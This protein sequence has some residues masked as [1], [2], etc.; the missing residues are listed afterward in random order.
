MP[1]CV[2]EN[3]F[4][5]F[6]KFGIKAFCC[7]LNSGFGAIILVYQD[8]FKSLLALVLRSGRKKLNS[9]LV[10]LA[11]DQFAQCLRGAA[12]ALSEDLSAKCTAHQ[13]KD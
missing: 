13:T 7:P 2:I 1:E 11:I 6:F 8:Q 5:C 12:V 4:N 10:K 9:V 3:Q